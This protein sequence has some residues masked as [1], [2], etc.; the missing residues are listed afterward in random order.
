MWV[1]FELVE[2]NELY[3]IGFSVLAIGIR[4][5]GLL[6]A[7]ECIHVAEISITHTNYD[8][9]QR[10]LGASHN[11]IDGLSH[12]VDDTIGN[13]QKDRKSLVVLVDPV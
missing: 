2:G 7:I 3:D 12:V 9:A 13:Q 4:V 6:V 1:L 5:Q 11:L 8:D 10:V